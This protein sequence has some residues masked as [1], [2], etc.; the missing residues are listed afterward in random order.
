MAQ[1]T[2]IIQPV[3]INGNLGGVTDSPYEYGEHDFIDIADWGIQVPVHATALTGYK[4]S[5]WE[6]S[7]VQIGN[8][9]DNPHN[10]TILPGYF[11]NVRVHFVAMGQ[12]D[13]QNQDWLWI[14][15]GAGAVIMVSAIAYTLYS[16]KKKPK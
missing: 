5:Y 11:Y 15:I 13:G 1:C 7:G 3:P 6:I 4:F 2:L 16:R 10:F 14:M 8:F 9:V 12:N